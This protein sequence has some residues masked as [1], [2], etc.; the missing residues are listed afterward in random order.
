MIFFLFKVSTL[1]DGNYTIL[2]PIAYQMIY[3]LKRLSNGD[4]YKPFKL[5]N[6]KTIN[7][8]KVHLNYF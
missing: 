1:F 5:K 6:A 2:S 8:L 7:T 3:D 4:L